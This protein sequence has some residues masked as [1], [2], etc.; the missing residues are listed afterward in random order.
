MKYTIVWSYHNMD[1]LWFKDIWVIFRYLMS[2]TFFFYRAAS[3]AY[4]GSQARGW[5]RAAASGLHHSHSNTGSELHLWP[6]PKVTAASLTHWA[7]PGIEPASSWI[8]V[9][10]LSTAP[11]WELPAVN[12]FVMCFW[13]ICAKGSLWYIFRSKIVGFKICCKFSSLQSNPNLCPQI[14]PIGTFTGSVKEWVWKLHFL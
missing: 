14:I 6:T 1:N 9:R 2:W 3:A 8:R 10:F 11:P 5:I 4:G 13:Y 7:R 12:I